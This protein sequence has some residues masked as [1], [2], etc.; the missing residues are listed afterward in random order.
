MKIKTLASGLC[1][2][3]TSMVAQASVV[4]VTGTPANDQLATPSAAS[5]NLG[6]LKINF[7][8]LTPFT[9]FAS[10]Y[11]TQGVSITSPDGLQAI[12]FSTQS[13]PNELFDTSALGSANLSILLN[14]GP[15]FDIG[16]GI[17]D[18][19]AVTIMIQALGAG[20]TAL[21]AAFAVTIT[22]A[23]PNPGN[24]YF[25]VEDSTPGLFG[26]QITESVSN[27]N[28]SGLAIDDVQV[29]YTPEPSSFVFLATGLVG[30]AGIWY[31]RMLKQQ[32]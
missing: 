2:L 8:G 14:Q 30:L 26:L 19:D 3:L 24:G 9:S 6:D 29:S 18:S 20:D 7:D 4:L 10:T 31:T 5:P 16:V 32:A 27:V 22:E 25:V 1:F 23:G 13:G 12:P 21:G 11:T 17:A 15:A 28:F